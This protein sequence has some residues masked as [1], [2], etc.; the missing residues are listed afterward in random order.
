[1]TKRAAAIARARKAK[2]AQKGAK[3]SE[4]PQAGNYAPKP[5]KPA[6]GQPSPT[7]ASSKAQQFALD[8]E[9]AGWE[10]ER[11]KDGNRKTVIARRGSEVIEVTWVKEVCQPGLT[12]TSGVGSRKLRNA[13]EA[14]RYLAVPEANVKHTARVHRDTGRVYRGTVP[15]DVETATDEEVLA[16]IVGKTVRWSNRYTNTPEV[17]RIPKDSGFTRITMSGK[18]RQVLFCDSGKNGTGFRAFAVQS[19][20]AV[21]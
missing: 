11:V 17:A 14:R 8:A 20:I 12:Y 1:M 16:A 21:G 10:A 7:T 4:S 2:H 13:A 19:L 3:P 18:H 15:F 9:A 6:S 5:G